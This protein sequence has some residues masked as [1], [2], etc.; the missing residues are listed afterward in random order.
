MNKR[1]YSLIEILCCVAI[2]SILAS[3]TSLAVY[4]CANHQKKKK[5]ENIY[6][7]RNLNIDILSGNEADLDGEQQNYQKLLENKIFG[8]D[9]E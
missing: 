7:I 5:I 6:Y 9:S 2:V 8:V 1:A 4:R 3:L